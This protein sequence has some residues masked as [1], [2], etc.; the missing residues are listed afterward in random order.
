MRI[1]PNSIDDFM[2]LPKPIFSPR[3]F[4][5]RYRRML[6]QCMDTYTEQQ[7]RDAQQVLVSLAR[8][9]TRIAQFAPSEPIEHLLIMEGIQEHLESLEYALGMRE[10]VLESVTL[11]GEPVSVW[12]V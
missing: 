6:R 9:A 2:L 4:T 12:S 8:Y 7:Q 5:F 1:E 10:R 3:L 11:N